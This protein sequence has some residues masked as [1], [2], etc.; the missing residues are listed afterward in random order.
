MAVA[1]TSAAAEFDKKQAKQDCRPEAGF[2]RTLRFKSLL[3][4]AFNTYEQELGL[5]AENC[6]TVSYTC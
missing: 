1:G 4:L 2:F 6:R 3:K 5:A